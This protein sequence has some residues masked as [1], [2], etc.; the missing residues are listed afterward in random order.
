MTAK[1]RQKTVRLHVGALSEALVHNISDL[2]DR[3]AKLGTVV[4]SFEIHQKPLLGYYYGYLTMRLSKSQLLKLRSSF[5]GVRYKGAQLTVNLARPDHQQ[6][7]E[8]DVRRNDGKSADRK[9]NAM[10]ARKRVARIQK[11]HANPFDLYNNLQGRMRKTPRKGD[12]K[13]MPTRVIIN[14]KL[15]IPKCRKTKLWGYDKTKNAKDL[16]FQYSNGKWKDGNGHVI[17]RHVRKNV[18]SLPSAFEED[19]K[20]QTEDMDQ[21]LDEE[22]NEEEGRNNALLESLMGSYDF[23]KPAEANEDLSSS[24]ESGSEYELEGPEDSDNDEDYDIKHTNC[25]KPTQKSLVEEYKQQH[26]EYLNKKEPNSDEQDNEDLDEEFIPSFGSKPE[27]NE[28]ASNGNDTEKLRS[29]L[30]PETASGFKFFEGE[31]DESDEEKEKSSKARQAI[32]EEH[33]KPN[34]NFGLFFAHFESPFLVAQTQVAKLK[35]FK[36]GEDYKYEDWFFDNRGQLNRAFRRRRREA[37]RRRRRSRR[38]L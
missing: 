10:F 27:T 29:L 5:N 16:S 19:T 21:D 7:W 28:V 22:I 31:S 12:L 26:P 37:E 8:K 2:E 23:D 1:D 30:N 35:D 38:I 36:V 25:V 11:A 32:I 20:E 34:R 24:Y 9:R 14:G 3:F 4:K 15:R 6:Q 33:I 13:N 18:L 17:E